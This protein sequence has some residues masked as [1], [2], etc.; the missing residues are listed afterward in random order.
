M[1]FQIRPCRINISEHKNWNSWNSELPKKTRLPKYGPRRTKKNSWFATV[2]IGT[3]INCLNYPKILPIFCWPDDPDNSNVSPNIGSIKFID[4]PSWV[5]H[6][7]CWI[8][9]RPLEA[10]SSWVGGVKSCLGSPPS[11]RLGC[12]LEPRPLITSY[13]SSSYHET[14]FT[15][16]YHDETLKRK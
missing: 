11:P 3:P 14:C 1:H 8:F 15:I 13:L 10:P 9:P 5:S 7:R 4:D 6:A 12:G 2:G 16:E